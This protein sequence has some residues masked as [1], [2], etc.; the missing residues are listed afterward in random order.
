MHPVL[1]HDI[2]IAG[3]G[4]IGISL[5]LELHSRGASVA[6]L[7]TAAAM[8]G[9]STAAAGMLAAD[10]PHN[11]AELHDL[12]AYSLSLYDRFLERITEL[13]GLHVPYQT[14][15]TIQYLDAA[16]IIRIAEKSVDPR[17]LAAAALQ[18]AR[19]S[20]I[21]LLE[22]CRE[23]EIHEEHSGVHVRPLNGPSLLAKSFVHA[24]GAWYRGAPAIAPRKGQ[25]LRV[26]IPSGMSLNEVHRS[27]SIYVV[28]RTA[29]PQAGTALIGATEEDAGF[30]RSVMQ[31]DLDQLRSRAAALL[32]ELASRHIAPQ[33]EAWAGLRPATADGLPVIGRL[34]DSPNQWI[35]GGHFRNGILLAPG[36]VQVLADLLENNPPGLN[37]TPFSPSRFLKPVP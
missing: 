10:D 31:N 30:D 2:V 16:S 4:L 23:L 7:D 36:T 6:V 13:S 35:A 37:L 28:P 25:M 9:A 21:R 29:G 33:V 24:S 32:P 27:A 12:A 14:T 15:A 17:Q 11:P 34:P 19:N 26:R 5:A 8:G 1:T 18:A 3:A 20:G 22:Q